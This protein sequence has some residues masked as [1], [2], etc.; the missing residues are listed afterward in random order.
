LFN[1]TSFQSHWPS[2]VKDSWL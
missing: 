2:I 1:Y